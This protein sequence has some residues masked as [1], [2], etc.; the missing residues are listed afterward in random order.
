MPTW[1]AYRLHVQLSASSASGGDRVRE[2]L[3]AQRGVLL[4]VLALQEAFQEVPTH[5]DGYRV[6]ICEQSL[7]LERG[8]LIVAEGVKLAISGRT[9]RSTLGNLG[10]EII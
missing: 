1:S 4:E 5:G 3:Y 7:V 6:G 2:V 10:G 8:R 9:K